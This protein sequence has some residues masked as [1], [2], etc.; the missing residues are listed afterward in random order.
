MKGKALLL[1]SLGLLFLIQAR[2]ICWSQTTTRL[3]VDTAG[4]EGDGPSFHPSISA[5]GRYVAF[6]SDS[7]NLVAADNNT[8]R[9]IFVRDRQTP[10][11][12]RVSVDSGGAKEAAIAL[13]PPSLPMADM[14][15]SSLRPTWWAA[16][17]ILFSLTSLFAT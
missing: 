8:S 4:V 17:P 13:P 1:L 16:M 9:D 6:E 7:E 5:D 2:G 3:S 15:P 12:T 11:T 14:W 10:T